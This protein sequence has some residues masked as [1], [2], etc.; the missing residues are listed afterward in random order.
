MSVIKK[1]ELL[2]NLQTTQAFIL[3]YTFLTVYICS[4]QLYTVSG[5]TSCVLDFVLTIF[6][7]L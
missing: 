2:N 4:L 3:F 1:S 7:T 5:H 6:V